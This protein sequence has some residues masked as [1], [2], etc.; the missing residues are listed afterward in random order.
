MQYAMFIVMR[1]I[2]GRETDDLA[3]LLR[4][5]LDADGETFSS[6]EVFRLHGMNG[7]LI[8]RV[9]ARMTEYVETRSGMPSHYS[10]YAKRGGKGGYEIEHIWADHAD[11]HEDEFSHPTEFAEYRNRIG[12]LL[13]LPKSFNASYGDLP[14]DK[15]VG[16]YDSQNLLAR[17]LNSNAYDHNPG[18]FQFIHASGLPFQSHAEFRRADID[19]RQELYRHLAEQIWDPDR[20]QLAAGHATTA[21]HV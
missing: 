16:H 5:R 6:N 3:T 14:Y 1:D 9:L 15:K 18:F 17:S 21:A 4:Q 10:E 13:L 19:V 20:L 12:D 8:H 7:R 2:R 11:R